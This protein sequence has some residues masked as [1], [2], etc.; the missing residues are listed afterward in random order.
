VE[1]GAFF[2]QQE[3]AAWAHQWLVDDLLSFTSLGLKLAFFS[4][5][6]LTGIH[7][8]LR[9]RAGAAAEWLYGNRVLIRLGD[10]APILH[11]LAMAF[12]R[13]SGS[14]PGVS[15]ERGRWII[16]GLFPV[17]LLLVYAA[18]QTPLSFF[19]GYILEHERG[20]ATISLGQ[21]WLDWAKSLASGCILGMFLGV[22]LFGLARRLRRSWWLWLWGAVAGGLF[23]WAMLTPYRARIYNDYTELAPGEL[24]SS[25]EALVHRAGFEAGK[26]EV[27]D[28]SRRTRRVGAH[29]MG[30][31]PTR[32]V[33]LADNLVK[34]FPQREI[35]VAMAHELGHQIHDH[36][37]HG[38]LK[39]V[40]AAFVF[41]LICQLLLLWAPRVKRFG[42]GVGADAAVLPL[43]LLVFQIVFLVNEPLSAWLD[44]KEERVADSEAL[45][46]TRDP[47][48]FCSLFIRLARKNKY[49]PDPPAWDQLLFG[50]HP[51]VMQRINFGF[52]WAKKN[53]LHLGKNA[54]PLPAPPS[55]KTRP[56]YSPIRRARSR[57]A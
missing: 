13:L 43:L 32:R 1:P 28:S 35:L 11:R 29:V 31:G 51:T 21:W 55:Q 53:G 12:E 2:S 36:G 33:V 9:R 15:V 52:E 42:L 25:I 26:V 48:A 45:R 20:L 4:V 40:L 37:K 3:L 27:K 34:E 54:L 16:D 47:A 44:R 19:S 17:L 56:D 7:L 39:A 8:V 50:H 49:H 6:M 46:L 23:L 22:G 24:R 30:Q 5:V 57:R 18:L 10:R 41:L 14:M 38:W